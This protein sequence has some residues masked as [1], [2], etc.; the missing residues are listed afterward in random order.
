MTGEL[1]SF[2]GDGGHTLQGYLVT[3]PGAAPG[4]QGALVVIHEIFGLNQDMREVAERLAGEGYVA[5]A[6]DLFHGRTRAL[7]MARIFGSI[8]TGQSDHSGTRDL[9]GAVDFLQARPDVDPS[10]VGAIGFCMGGTFAMA[11][12]LHDARVKAIAPFY[13]F[14]PRPRE[15]LARLCPVVASYPERD[16]TAGSGRA[17]EGVLAQA[18]VPHDVKV[19]PG[20]LH[21]FMN[22]HGGSFDERASADAWDRTLRFFERH[23]KA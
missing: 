6:V 10:R 12:S 9:R 13:G 11:L 3:P 14:N 15:A 4:R 19:Y 20:A 8:L 18:S 2:A 23:L 21:S 16:L 22:P 1:V 17:L 5:L 7:C